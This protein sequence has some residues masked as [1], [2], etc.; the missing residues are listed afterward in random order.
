MTGAQAR[1]TFANVVGESP[2]LK[3]AMRLARL[4]ATSN[5]TVFLHGET[6]TGKEIFAQSIHT[7]SARADGP[8]VAVNCA[9]IP[10][11]LINT[12]LRSGEHT[13]ELQSPSYLVCR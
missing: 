13:S 3:E 4:A 1:L 2:A 6:G 7:S 8:F 5:S 10:R 9:A 12:E 11:E